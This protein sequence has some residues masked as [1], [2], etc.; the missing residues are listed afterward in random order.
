MADQRESNDVFTQQQAQAAGIMTRNVIKDDFGLEVPVD[1][2]PIPSLGVIYPYGTPLHKAETVEIRSMTAREEDILTSRALI[3]KGT[4]I[5]QLLKSCI[6]DKS[7]DVESMIAGDRNAVMIALRITGYGAEYPCEISCPECN[8]TNR[9]D[10]NLAGLPIKN[11]SISP[12][13]E[14]A[15]LFDFV[16]P[17]TKKR[18][19]FKFLT[20]LDET[21][22]SQEADRRKKK[23]GVEIES[24]VTSRL[25]STIV[26]IDG[27][28]DRNKISQFV[29]SMPAGD[30]RAL[31]K[32]MDDN[33]P[34]IEMKSW[35]TC[36]SCGEESEVRLPM[37]ASFFWP[38][39]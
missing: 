35:M 31:R 17:M 13:V 38:D 2:V 21:E 23:L 30:S 15:N 6:V 36:S 4:V 28:K 34:G 20:G 24:L 1:A 26:E 19:V 33:E 8:E 5:S 3:K 11:L 9:Q 32:Y 39:N 22:I 29:R 16:L 7:V 27:I 12:I 25:I 10:F 37:G 18:V 14:G